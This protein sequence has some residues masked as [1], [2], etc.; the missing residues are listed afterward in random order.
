MCKKKKCL[1]SCS[2][3]MHLGKD[4]FT[5]LR[6]VSHPWFLWWAVATLSSPSLLGDT[7][8]IFLRWPKTIQQVAMQ[9]HKHSC[10]RNQRLPVSCKQPLRTTESEQTSPTGGEFS[11]HATKIISFP[12]F[13]FTLPVLLC[14]LLKL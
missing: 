2:N 3:H 4:L 9:L 14:H 8:A 11:G 6:A 13:T 5:F 7:I 10:S 1:S 12:I